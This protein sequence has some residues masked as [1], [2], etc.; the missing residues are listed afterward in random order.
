MWPVAVESDLEMYKEQ[1]EEEVSGKGLSEPTVAKF[2]P[3]LEGGSSPDPAPPAWDLQTLAGKGCKRWNAA[4]NALGNFGDAVKP[5]TRV[6]CAW[7]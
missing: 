5:A 1:D 4:K 6:I 7:E 2:D 3:P